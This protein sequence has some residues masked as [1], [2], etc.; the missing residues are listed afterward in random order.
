M[1]RIVSKIPFFWLEHSLFAANLEN[2]ILGCTM[3]T[4]EPKSISL[5]SQLIL[6][7]PDRNGQILSG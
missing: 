5:L 3:M 2:L 4:L 6:E 1:N 7:E